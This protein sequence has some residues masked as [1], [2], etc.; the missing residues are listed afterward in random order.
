MESAIGME[1]CGV[2]DRE[3][4]SSGPARVKVPAGLG[5][6]DHNLISA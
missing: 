4:L 3:N 6:T 2:V 1:V 5:P